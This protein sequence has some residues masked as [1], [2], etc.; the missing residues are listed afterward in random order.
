[1]CALYRRRRRHMNRIS[2]GTH[3]F[4]TSTRLSKLSSDEK[5]NRHGGDGELSRGMDD[6][7]ARSN[8][9]NNQAAVSDY[10]KHC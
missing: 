6:D 3:K 2:E 7:Q 1:M 4:N 8:G 9:G 5:G 10:R